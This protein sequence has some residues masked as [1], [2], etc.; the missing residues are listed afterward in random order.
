ME[1]LLT[2]ETA[3]E[4][5]KSSNEEGGEGNFDVHFKRKWKASSPLGPPR[6]KMVVR[7]FPWHS[8]T[9]PEA[10]Q[11]VSSIGEEGLTPFIPPSD[12]LII[13]LPIIEETEGETE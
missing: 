6:K 11:E 12:P 4:A 10:V 1:S 3:G 9:R 8:L 2:R 13:R 5:D 7:K